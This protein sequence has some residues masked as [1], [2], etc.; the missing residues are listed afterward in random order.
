MLRSFAMTMGRVIARRL[1]RADD[2]ILDCFASLAMTVK[3]LAM[4]CYNVI[5]RSVSDEAISTFTQT[6]L[7]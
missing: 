6:P 4:T 3:R 2:A 7:V 1:V 5:T